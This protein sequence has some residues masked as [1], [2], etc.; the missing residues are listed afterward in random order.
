MK[1][2]ASRGDAKN[3]VLYWY[4][5]CLVAIDLFTKSKK[6]KKMSSTWGT[7]F[8]RPVDTTFSS[9][10]VDFGLHFGRVLGA[11]IGKNTFRRGSQ[12]TMKKKSCN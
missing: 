7:F 11:K 10:L 1:R 8:E 3:V 2:G 12:K 6:N 5:Q 4:L 9:I